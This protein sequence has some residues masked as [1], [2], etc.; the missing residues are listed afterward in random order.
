VF[1]IS[2]TEIR[3]IRRT[4]IGWMRANQRDL[5]WRR[6]RDPWAVFVAEQMLQQTQV[7]RVI[8][9][10][11]AFLDRFPTVQSAAE[12]DASEIVRMWDGLGYNR[13]ALQLHRCAVSI[14]RNGGT[15]PSTIET[16]LVLPGVGAYTS[17]AVL[18]FAFERDVAV[19]DTNVARILARSFVGQPMLLREAQHLADALVPNNK[20][21]M[22][23]QGMLDFGATICTKRNPKCDVCPLEGRCVWNHQR[24]EDANAPDPAVGS[25]GVPAKQ[26]TFIGSDRQGRGKLISALRTRSLSDAEIPLVMGWPHDQPRVMRV[27]QTLIRD[28]LVCWDETETTLRLGN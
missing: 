19:V 1:A 5:P 25:G 15:F 18:A 8:P 22:W 20:G 21:W 11:A 28:R 4:L 14:T 13:R 2:A 27:L 17:R 12:A 9:K 6:T 24:N 10:W 23:N 26:S 16:L 3:S 7:S